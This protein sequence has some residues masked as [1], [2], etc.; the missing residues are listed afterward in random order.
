MAERSPHRPA[1][2]V[3]AYNRAASLSRLLTAISKGVFRVEPVT[4]HI[5]IDKGPSADVAQVA[6]E[7]EWSHGEKVVEA[8]PARMGLKAHLLYCG[9]LAKRYGSIV[10]LEDDLYVAPAFYSYAST[11]IGEYATDER[12]AGVSLYHYEAAESCRLPFHPV[13][14]GRSCYF[15]QWTSSWGQAWTAAQWGAFEAWLGGGEGKERVEQWLPEFVRGWEPDSWKR[16]HI[17]YLRATGKYFVY[18]RVGLSTH[19]GEA[20]THSVLRGADQTPLVTGVPEWSWEGLDESLAVYDAWF[21]L[22]SDR[23]VQM[24][25]DL[26]GL[27]FEVDLYGAKE[28]EALKAELV[29][30][31]RRGANA[32]RSYALDLLPPIANVVQGLEGEG[33]YLLRKEEVEF[34]SSS[35]EAYLSK[36]SGWHRFFLQTGEMQRKLKVSVVLLGEEKESDFVDVVEVLGEEREMELEI[37]WV[38]NGKMNGE[39]RELGQGKVREL[40][41]GGDLMEDLETA[42][43]AATGDLLY[44]LVPGQAPFMPSLQAACNIAQTYPDS[45]AFL[46]QPPGRPLPTQRWTRDRFARSQA[47]EIHALLGP[48]M[49][50]LRRPHWLKHFHSPGSGLAPYWSALFHDQLPIAIEVQGPAAPGISLPLNDRFHLHAQRS[51]PGRL[52]SRLF[53]PAFLNNS[54]LRW[55]HAQI[56]QYPPLIRRAPDKPSGWDMAAY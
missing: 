25:P 55:I 40:E 24:Q 8:H 33:I 2:V 11:A 9:G 15:M 26:R 43:N 6:E 32:L 38:G 44:T 52:I 5:S 42:F 17:A 30:T 3:A 19:F 1:I 31:S 28:K 39:L 29:L 56:E 18:P 41:S 51:L 27:D 14:T 13:E 54:K 37:L 20:G 23:V 35:E 21:E 50:I 7:F 4:L 34:S 22:L 45:N 16:L 48:G 53:R 36:T 10:L 46:L 49:C 47:A 12:I